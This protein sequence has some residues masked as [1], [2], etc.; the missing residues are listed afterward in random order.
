MAPYKEFLARALQTSPVTGALARSYCVA[1]GGRRCRLCNAS[2]FS[3]ETE[4]AAK[5]EAVRLFWQQHFATLTLQPL[6]ASPRG[7]LY[8]SI[9]KRKVSLLGRDVVCGLIDPDE[10]DTGGILPVSACAIEPESH[11]EVYRRVISALPSPALRA[12]TQ[13][14]RYVIVRG[15]EKNTL[16]ILSVTDSAPSLMRA[17]NALSRVL[18]TAP[19]SVRAVYLHHDESDGRYYLGSGDP[20]GRVRMHKL[21]GTQGLKHDVEGKRFFYPPAAFS[22]VNHPALEVLTAAVRSLLHPDRATTLLD[23]YCGYGLFGLVLAGSFARVIGADISPD[24]ISAANDNATRQKVR[25]VR[26]LRST[27]DEESVEALLHRCRSP[28]AVVL[29]PPRGGTAEGIIPLL[30]SY[31]PSRVVHLFCN[32][33][34]MPEELKRWE[35]EGYQVD[36]AVP[37]DM[38]PG[39]AAL[40]IVAGLSRKAD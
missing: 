37:V 36:A 19:S 27:L 4:L 24:A 11:Q 9:S 15:D 28:L 1:P 31:A 39:T 17:A 23:L 5:R 16:V 35:S 30:A 10:T 8:R 22:Q 3:Y 14:L 33:D 32:I 29:D 40:E 2:R 20:A 25:N 6:A 7:R 34:G 12:L 21:F 38:F 18:T 26:F 13:T